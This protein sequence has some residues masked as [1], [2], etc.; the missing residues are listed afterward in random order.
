VETV[1]PQILH[2]RNFQV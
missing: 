2:V 1:K